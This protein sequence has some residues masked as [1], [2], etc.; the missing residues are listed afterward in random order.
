MLNLILYFIVMTVAMLLLSR[1]LPGFHVDGWVPALI[2]S[3]VLA[4]INAVL[5]PVLFVL[6]LPF[7]IL[8]LGLFLLVLNAFCL[9]LAQRLVPGFDIHGFLTTLLASIILALVGILWKAASK[10]VSQRT[11]RERT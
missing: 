3:V 2:G 8:T 1:T 10:E 11:K 4:A 7:T 5:K 9:W 6:T